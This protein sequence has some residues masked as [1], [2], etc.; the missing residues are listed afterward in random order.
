MMSV[1]IIFGRF[2]PPH[3]GHRAAWEMAS[4]NDYWYIGTNKSTVGPKDPLP[5]DEKIQIMSSLW[6]ESKTHIVSEQSWLTLAARVYTEFGNI[7]LKVY[8]D[9]KWVYKTILDYNGVKNKPHGYYKFDHISF[10]PTPRLG[11]ATEL[12][13]AVRT[14]NSELFESLSGISSKI[15][16]NNQSVYEIVAKYLKGYNN[17][18]RRP[19][20][21]SRNR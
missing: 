9:E 5:F 8:T 16:I 11:S 14:E 12:R 17:E 6:P 10:V 18:H 20:E 2:N 4:Q 21:T 15:L 7:K 3:K 1:G 19:K 13:N